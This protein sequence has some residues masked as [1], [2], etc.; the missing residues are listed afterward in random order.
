MGGA[1]VRKAS[2]SIQDDDQLSLADDVVI[3]VS[4]AAEKLE[5]ALA[6]WQ[7][8]TQDKTAI[9]VG[10]STGGFTQI[11]LDGDAIKV[12]AVDVGHDQLHERLRRRGRVV[13]LEG[14]D[15]RALT[16]DH[17]PEQVDL[18]VCDVSFISLKK[19]LPVPLTFL[20]PGGHVIALIKP[21]FEAGRD[22]VGRGGMV[23]D[24]AVH[25]EIC[26]DIHAWFEKECGLKVLGITDSPILGGDGNKEFLIAASA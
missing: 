7:I 16:Q 4:R 14:L 20:K 23:K 22:R 18:I 5:A 17:V 12:Y 6:H 11:L 13:C 8:D 9:D 24:E 3:R 21:Q 1:P 15:A 25:R 26:A 19:A 10:A 2:Q